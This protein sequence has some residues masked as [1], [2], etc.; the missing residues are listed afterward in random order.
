MQLVAIGLLACFIAGCQGPRAP[1]RF[2]GTP[3]VA[4]DF[5]PEAVSVEL[6]EYT[7]TFAAS[8]EHAA[9][10]IAAESDDPEVRRNTVLWKL[11]AP[12]TMN[13]ACY[14]YDP[15]AGLVDAWI[16]ARQMEELF[17]TGV[18]QDLFGDQQEIAVDVSRALVEQIRAVASDVTL[19]PEAFEKVEQTD[20]EAW[21]HAHPLEGL[22]FARES[23]IAR[24]A[25][26]AVA[27]RGAFAQ[28]AS[29]EDQMSKISAQAR[30]YLAD[31]PKRFQWHA[32][33]LRDDMLR[34]TDVAQLSASV[35]T[36]ADAADRAATVA[37]ETADLVRSE[38][39]IILEE[40]DRQRALLTEDLDDER[41]LI[42]QTF[43]DERNAVLEAVAVERREVIYAI[44][45]QRVAT[46]DRLSVEREAV[47]AAIA[48]QVDRIVQVF[49]QERSDVL[50]ELTV[51]LDT[52]VDQTDQE[53]ND[54][55]DHLFVRLV[56]L[57]V[58]LIMATPIVA[59]VY[60]RVWPRRAT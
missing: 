52:A 57:V 14:R 59:H 46:L 49:E 47:G 17:T 45:E 50:R 48:E 35:E 13:V 16:L 39:A 41:A 8:V 44:D 31:L 34:S 5:N 21:V 33:L 55:V 40:V 36:I 1:G 4:K 32:E 60:A 25:D 54:A 27:A 51:M 12:P 18:G 24:F 19:S 15:I 10:R 11:Y 22:T 23:S 53:L 2:S 42:L 58:V 30:V 3:A 37:E 6:N 26:R 56:Q 29:L 28:V 43:S 38:R 20:I 7:A 9:D